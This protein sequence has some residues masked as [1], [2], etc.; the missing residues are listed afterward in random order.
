MG[1][2]RYVE[3]MARPGSFAIATAKTCAA[4]YVD[5]ADYPGVIRAAGDLQADIHRVTGCTPAITHDPPGS[6]AHAIV[7]GSIDRS[8]MVR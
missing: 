2:P 6:G 4:I 8:P 7:I 1:Q 5:A 3:N